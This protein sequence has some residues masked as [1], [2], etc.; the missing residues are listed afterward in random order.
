M[1]VSC[2]LGGPGS[3]ANQV[4]GGDDDLRQTGAAPVGQ[5]QVAGRCLL[6]KD[7]AAYDLTSDLPQC[8]VAALV[9]RQEISPI[10]DRLLCSY[11]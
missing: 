7:Q 11:R 2:V 8:G 3:E 5:P 4:A 9:T 6:D 10:V 1:I